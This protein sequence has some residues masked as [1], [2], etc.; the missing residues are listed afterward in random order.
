MFIQTALRPAILILS[1]SPE[2]CKKCMYHR[3]IHLWLIETPFP[4]G[5]LWLIN[6][7]QPLTKNLGSG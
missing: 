5:C 7:T 3:I 2:L 6:E 4:R 1:V